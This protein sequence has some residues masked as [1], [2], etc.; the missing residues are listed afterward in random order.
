MSAPIGTLQVVPDIDTETEDKKLVIPKQ[1]SSQSLSQTSA[2][3][4][5]PT[6]VKVITSVLSPTQRVDSPQL[7]MMSPRV[8]MVRRRGQPAL[9]PPIQ[10]MSSDAQPLT[11]AELLAHRQLLR[12]QRMD[13]GSCTG[14]W[15]VANRNS[16][17]GN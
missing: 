11:S 4:I 7:L 5:T 8:A 10:Q 3:K 1:A 14:A 9:H 12:V 13:V 2:K 16:G 15:S 6:E 17:T